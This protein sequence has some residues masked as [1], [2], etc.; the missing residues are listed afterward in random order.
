MQG[1]K[2]PRD[3]GTDFQIWRGDRESAGLHIEF[4]LKMHVCWWVAWGRLWSLKRLSPQGHRELKRDRIVLEKIFLFLAAEKGNLRL[5]PWL[6]SS[7][8]FFSSLFPASLHLLWRL[9]LFKWHSLPSPSP[10]PL[11]ISS[12]N[13]KFLSSASCFDGV[14]P[15]HL[16]F[17]LPFINIS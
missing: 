2:D 11:P 6:L 7:C 5:N 15:S 8:S 3:G 12:G 1:K 13:L 16:Q 4:L 14:V 17:Y 9:K 10:S